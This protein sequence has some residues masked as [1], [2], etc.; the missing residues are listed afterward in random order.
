VL[1]RSVCVFSTRTGFMTQSVRVL[2]PL[3]APDAGTP[4]ER[5]DALARALAARLGEQLRATP[6]QWC[7]FRP[8]A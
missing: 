3:T 2:E 4:R 1:F 5:V 8:L 7:V 6:G